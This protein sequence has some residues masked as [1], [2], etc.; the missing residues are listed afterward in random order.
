MASDATR[1]AAEA[2]LHAL[3]LPEG[4]AGWVRERRAAAR[5]RLLEAGAPVRRD[6]YWRF[7][8]PARLTAPIATAEAG[9]A[10]AQAAAVFGDV[11]ALRVRLV[12]GRLRAD[13]SDPLALDGAAI[14]PLG[15]VLKQDISIVRELVGQLELAAQEKVSRP[16]AIL[17]TAAATEGL[18]IQAHG[19]TVRPVLVSYDQIGEGAS[20]V[21]HVIRVEAGASLTLLEAGV[22]TNSVMEVEVADGGTFHHVRVQTGERAPAVTHVFARIGA[23]AEFKTFTLTADGVLTRNEVVIDIVGDHASGHIA[24]AVLGK[25][26]AHIDNTV[27]VTH[28]A[29]HGESRQVFKNVLAGAS[30]GI[31]QGKI[32]VR[33]GAQKTDG[34][35]ISQSVLLEEGAQFLAKPELEI[36]ADDVK[37]SHGSTTGALDETALFYLRSRGVPKRVAESMLV[38]AFVDEAISEI[39]DE[40]MQERMRALVAKWM[41]GRT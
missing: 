24:G 28:S 4:E 26:D 21:R 34:Y 16:L 37:C 13:L 36:Y 27:F 11:D 3:A 14:A 35:Q 6:E 22:P 31:F 19:A 12:N 15:E 20:L 30:R 5:S 38:A 39:A 32:F 41:A 1:K 25:G 18:A 10:P 2:L 9:E 29:E 23:E 33:A 40:A 7:T 17:N 8:D